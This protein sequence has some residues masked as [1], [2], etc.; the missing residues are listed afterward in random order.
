MGIAQV[1]ANLGW[2]GEGGGRAYRRQSRVIAGIGNA[3]PLNHGGTRQ[4]GIFRVSPL[5]S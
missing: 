1:Y 5:E 2:I 3:N 4:S